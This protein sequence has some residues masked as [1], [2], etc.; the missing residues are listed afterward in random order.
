VGQWERTCT[1]RRE[2]WTA[3]DERLDP[4]SNAAMPSRRAH[5]RTPSCEAAGIEMV[6]RIERRDGS[7]G[8]RSTCSVCT[9]QWVYYWR[10]DLTDE[11][12]R[13]IRREGNCLYQYELAQALAPT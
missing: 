7:S 12:G 11:R 8:W 1:C 3:P 10:P 2:V 5:R 6:V 4:N 9:S 13:A